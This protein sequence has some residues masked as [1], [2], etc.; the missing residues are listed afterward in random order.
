MPQVDAGSDT[1]NQTPSSG[2]EL[3][4]QRV[5]KHMAAAAALQKA[6]S[7]IQDIATGSQQARA[8][9]AVAAETA[10]EAE[11]DSLA[12]T[13][14]QGAELF[15]GHSQAEA[16]TYAGQDSGNAAVMV[17]QDCRM[18]QSM[19]G[20]GDS[21]DEQHGTPVAMPSSTPVGAAART[22]CGC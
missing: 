19:A 16:D 21:S 22:T 7:N 2:D 20:P 6:L 14:Q 1:P 17:H 3:G 18:L 15:H 4:L 9:A 8:A 11:V 13:L 5:A 12:H 10:A